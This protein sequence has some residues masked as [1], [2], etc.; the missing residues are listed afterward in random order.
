MRGCKSPQPLF[1]KRGLSKPPFHEGGL[2]GFGFPV[3][4]R[5]GNFSNTHFV[6]QKIFGLIPLR[7]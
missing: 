7:A 4:E 3:F 2:G 6:I 5:N 1:K